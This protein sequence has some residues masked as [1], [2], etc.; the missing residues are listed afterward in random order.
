MLKFLRDEKG[1]LLVVAVVLLFSILGFASMAIDMGCLLTAKNQLQS[2]VDASA[3]SG[4][5]GLLISQSEAVLRSAAI[6]GMNTCLNQPVVLGSENVDFPTT[7]QVRVRVEQPVPLYFAKI[8]G[9]HS[10]RVAASAVAEIGTIVGTNGMRPWAIPDMKW[11]HGTSVMLKSGALGAPATNPSFFY[12]VDFPPLNNGDPVP[13]AKTYE[14]NIINGSSCTVSIGDELLVEPGNMVGPTN[15]GVDVLLNMDPYADWD[16]TQVVKS[17][18][19][20]TSSP[21]I[22]K[23]PLYDPNYPPDSGKNSLTVVGLASFFVTGVHHGTVK[24]IFMEKITS[25]RIGSGNSMLK[26][27]RLVL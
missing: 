17:L 26:G 4:A 8:M 27:V 18:Y 14:G 19:P 10:V 20:G 12:A 2:A 13:G 23:I 11:T 21:R 7:S 24:G 15:H 9:I 16:G 1:N 22:V 25:G 5:S 3:L 6:G